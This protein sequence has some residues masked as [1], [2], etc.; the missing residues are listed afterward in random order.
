MN[1]VSHYAFSLLLT[2]LIARYFRLEGTVLRRGM[3]YTAIFII[4]FYF[5][6]IVDSLADVTY[7]P[8]DASWGDPFFTTWHVFIYSCEAILGILVLKKDLR[9]TTGLVGSVGFDIWDWSI[10]RFL[11][12]HYG[13]MIPRVHNVA[14]W[15]NSSLFFW[16]PNLRNQQWAASIEVGIVGILLILWW[17]I[18]VSFERDAIPGNIKQVS[19][20]VLFFGFWRLL[21]FF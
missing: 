21:T 2:I 10:G 8:A 15:I 1:G 19:G 17:N 12:K 3:I 7:H 18:R 14:D 9:Y 20:L 4:N 11:T 5:H 6:A 13:I 16:L